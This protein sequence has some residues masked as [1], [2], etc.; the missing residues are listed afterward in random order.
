MR[1]LFVNTS[2]RCGRTLLAIP[3]IAS[4]ETTYITETTCCYKKADEMARLAT[5]KSWP[6]VVQV[7][8]L[9]TTHGTHNCIS[10]QTVRNR[11]RDGGLSARRL[12]VGCVLARRLRVNRVIWVHMNAGLD[13]NGI[14]FFSQTSRGLPFMS[15]PSEE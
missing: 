1:K 3:E 13:N 11:L 12:Y 9:H 10:A 8:A 14:T 15:I 2:G 5:T 4:G 6:K 7:S